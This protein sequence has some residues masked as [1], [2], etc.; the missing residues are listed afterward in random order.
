MRLLCAQ[1]GLQEVCPRMKSE[2]EV[3]SKMDT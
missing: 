2:R 3:I 1:A